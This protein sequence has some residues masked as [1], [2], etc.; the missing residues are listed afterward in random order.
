MD[1]IVANVWIK[2]LIKIWAAM[3]AICV[4][5]AMLAPLPT[6]ANWAL[7]FTKFGHL[8]N[9]NVQLSDVCLAPKRVHL[10]LIVR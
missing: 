8:V 6:I 5:R 4:M 2:I 1:L 10:P 9:L 3:C 7:K